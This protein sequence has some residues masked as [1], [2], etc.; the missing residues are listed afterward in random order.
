MKVTVMLDKRMNNV[1]VY[2]QGDRAVYIDLCIA[3]IRKYSVGLNFTLLSDQNVR[4][5]L[6]LP[7]V[8]SKLSVVH[9]ADYLR[10]ALLH[11][12]GGMWLDA[13]TIVL[14]PLSKYI[15][16]LDKYKFL[17]FGKRRS[18]Q[19]AIIAGVP[20]SLILSTWFNYLDRKI[21]ESNI[22]WGDLGPIAIKKILLDLYGMDKHEYYNVSSE[23]CVP[24]SCRDW[25]DFFSIRVKQD[26]IL[27][28]TGMVMLYN[29]FMKYR[30]R[31]Y[32]KVCLM[33]SD[34]FISKLFRKSLNYERIC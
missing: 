29:K 12:Y 23:H 3:T 13:D 30:L 9:R 15:S 10:V 26:V 1:W 5:Y 19:T 31:Q 32:N 6:K 24:I 16:F 20:D 18:P 7:E 4:E 2:W 11:K 14:K 8:Y 27:K 17:G 34:M 21:F 28:D 22:S 33:E 25:K